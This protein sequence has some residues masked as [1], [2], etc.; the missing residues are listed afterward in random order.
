MKSVVLAA[1]LAGTVFS[2]S[3]NAQSQGEWTLGVGVGFLDP[4]SDNGT[5]AGARLDINN[6]TRPIF[7]AEYFIRDNIGIEILA[8]TP[9]KHD[10]KLDGQHIGNTDH[11]PP[12]ISVNYHFPTYNAWKPYLGIGANYTF[13]FDTHSN[14][15][16]LD[17]DNSFSASVQAGID[18][19]FTDRDAAR[20]NIRWFDLDADVKLNGD[21]I[22]KAKIQPWLFSV[23]Y[24]RSF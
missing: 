10:L 24:V 12:T 19:K 20:V 2:A 1:A 7:T 21:K 23:G 13:F 14:L 3:A 16:D 8:A 9:F 18:Y 5:V 6:N 15:G 11:L 4:K 17:I 22:G